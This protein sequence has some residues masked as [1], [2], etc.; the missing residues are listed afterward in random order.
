MAGM[1][2]GFNQAAGV[3]SAFSGFTQVPVA[4]QQSFHQAAANQ[5]GFGSAVGPTLGMVNQ[6]PTQSASNAGGAFCFGTKRIDAARHPPV[7]VAIARN[8]KLT[9]DARRT[10]SFGG[11]G[12]K[13]AASQFG[14]PKMDLQPVHAVFK[15]VGSKRPT[16]EQMVANQ[17]TEKTEVKQTK[18]KFCFRCFTKGHATAY[19]L[20]GSSFL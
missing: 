2:S 11:P 10:S 19:I 20:L 4:P 16:Q 1:F 9:F 6:A 14:A 15:R 3:Q 5:F 17:D 7:E 8:K 13:K 18:P 12:N